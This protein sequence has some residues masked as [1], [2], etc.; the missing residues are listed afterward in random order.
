MN[1]GDHLLYS[2]VLPDVGGDGVDKLRFIR[3]KVTVAGN[4]C[5]STGKK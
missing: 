5:D 4:E 3:Q 1:N 2:W